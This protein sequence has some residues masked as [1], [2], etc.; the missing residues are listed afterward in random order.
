MRA[1]IADD[2]ALGAAMKL[3]KKVQDARV[4]FVLPTRVGEVEIR[5]DVP[6]AAI[7]AAWSEIRS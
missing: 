4:R 1:D 3:D 6:G 2:D 5:D 7:S